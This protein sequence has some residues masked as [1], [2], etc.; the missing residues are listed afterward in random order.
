MALRR[1]TKAND[2][3]ALSDP[4]GLQQRLLAGFPF[5]FTAAQA[6][7]LTEINADL[8]LAQPM[9]RLVQGDVGCGKTAVAAAAATLALGAGHQVALMAPTEL[10]A[11]QHAR[12]LAGWFT[13]LEIPLTLVTGS[14][15]ARA[16][17]TPPPPL[18][19]RHGRPIAGTHAL[20]PEI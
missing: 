19:N 4:R 16:R 14:P 7:V 2:R 13:P 9:T 3:L 6:R 11:E 17:R 1:A 18:A 12:T 10:L 15:P 5:R 20:L 8:A